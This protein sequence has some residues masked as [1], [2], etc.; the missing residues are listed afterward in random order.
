MGEDV[1]SEVKLHSTALS[2]SGRNWVVFQLP[3][4]HSSLTLQH[5]SM[6]WRSNC[7]KE[8]NH[9]KSYKHIKYFQNKLR[10]WQM[11]LGRNDASNFPA[12]L[13][14]LANRKQ[15]GETDFIQGLIACPKNSNPVLPI[16]ELKKPVWA[17]S[18]HH[19]RLMMKVL[20]LFI[21]KCWRSRERHPNSG[22]PQLRF[23]S[24]LP[25]VALCHVWGNLHKKI[26]QNSIGDVLHKL[27]SL[28]LGSHILSHNSHHSWKCW[29]LKFPSTFWSKL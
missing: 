23:L 19:S 29:C 3:I 17:S 9:F 6:T 22:I 15:A 24:P 21:F 10:L 28:Y 25:R 11:Q 13:K 20:Q 26:K 5:M 4:S 1:F 27:G 7:R 12:P 8:A 16:L 18:L 2:S 14:V